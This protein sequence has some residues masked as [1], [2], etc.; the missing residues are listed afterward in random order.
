MRSPVAAL[1]DTTPRNQ[2]SESHVLADPTKNINFNAVTANHRVY[3][4]VVDSEVVFDQGLKPNESVDSIDI[5]NAEE[6]TVIERGPVGGEV[7]IL[8]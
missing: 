4:F 7:L 3:D 6:Y 2:N 8:I 5:V 1:R